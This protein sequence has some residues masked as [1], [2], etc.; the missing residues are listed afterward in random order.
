MEE[1][2]KS[3]GIDNKKIV[4]D[5]W[6]TWDIFGKLIRVNETTVEWEEWENKFDISIYNEEIFGFKI[7]DYINSEKKNI[8]RAKEKKRVEKLTIR[9]EIDRVLEW[10][11]CSDAVELQANLQW[12]NW[13]KNVLY[14]LISYLVV[15]IN[16][17]DQIVEREWISLLYVQTKNGRK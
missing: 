8:Q 5:F 4:L 9:E 10:Q 14:W 13:E 11:I 17:L 12:I 1:R 16:L 6:M 15:K 7:E 2:L 3:A